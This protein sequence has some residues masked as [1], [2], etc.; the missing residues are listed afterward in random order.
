MTRVHAAG[1]PELDAGYQDFQALF[2][3]SLELARGETVA[4]V[5]A[6]GAGKSTLLMTIAGALRPWRGQIALDGADVTGQPDYQRARAGVVLVP[7]GRRLFPSL[8]AEENILVPAARQ[9]AGPWTLDAL[10]ELFPMVAARRTHR[11]GLLSGGE[12]QAV[13]IAR[14]LAANPRV[15]LLDEVSLGLAPAIVDSFYQMLPTI[16]ASGVSI[17]L[18]EQDIDRALAASARTLCLLEGRVVLSGDSGSLDRAALIAA[19]FGAPAGPPG[20]GPPNHR[21]GGAGMTWLNDVV[22][23]IFLGGAYALTAVGLSLM[24]GVMRLVNLAHG[25]L[26]VCGT[27]LATTVMAMFGVP[28][29]VALLIMVPLAFL[30]GAV[31]QLSLFDRALRSGPTAPLL[32]TFG[33]SVI[34]ENLLQQI[35]SANTRG[36]PAGNLDVAAAHLGGLVL[37]WLAMLK[38]VLAVL[39]IGGLSALLQRTAWGRRVRATSDDLAIARLQGIRVRPLF[40]SVTGIAIAA[41]ALAGTLNAVTTGVYPTLGALTLIFAFE[42]VIIGGLGSLWGTLLGGMLLGVTQVVVSQVSVPY[43]TLASQ[44][45]FLVVLAVR[46]QGLLGTAQ[47]AGG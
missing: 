25:D 39:V 4:L 43:A 46:P 42:A 40:A 15:L 1:G 7:E 36:V 47:A 2:G 3:V 12:Q 32:V 6:N 23:G 30:L 35:Y 45:L 20:A 17:L 34:I 5:G 28:L 10:Y 18:V 26:A 33:L 19:Y 9:E 24:F 38:L 22:Q 31:L 11:A 37:P 16:Q 29:W 27:Y 13:A 8:T 44:L 21:T 14:A 41:A